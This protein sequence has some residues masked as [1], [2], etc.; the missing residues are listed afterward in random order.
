MSYDDTRSWSVSPPTMK[1]PNQPPSSSGGYSSYG[2]QHP[3]ITPSAPI[4][5]DVHRIQYGIPVINNG[6]KTT[7]SSSMNDGM[8]ASYSPSINDGIKNSY[9]P[10]IND[11][12]KASYSPSINDVNK[13]SYSPSTNDNLSKSSPIHNNVSMNSSMRKSTSSDSISKNYYIDMTP[14]NSSSLRQ[15][16]IDSPII[17][18]ERPA[19]VITQ[20]SGPMRCKTLRVVVITIDVFVEVCAIMDHFVYNGNIVASGKDFTFITVITTLI[21]ILALFIR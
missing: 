15:P 1:Y 20:T 2:Q 9:N 13:S 4:N 17:R 7:Y 11:G 21:A 10:S 5:D 18:V 19:A 6:M 16:L 3:Y 14:T 8:K 12:I